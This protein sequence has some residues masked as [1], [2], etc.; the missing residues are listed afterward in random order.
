MQCRNHWVHSVL[1]WHALSVLYRHQ[2]L[3]DS[4]ECREMERRGR[5]E[6]GERNEGAGER[7]REGGGE[8][9]KEKHERMTGK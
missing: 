8:K 5:G 6:R 1:Q 2:Q 7:E 9:R 4:I 3:L